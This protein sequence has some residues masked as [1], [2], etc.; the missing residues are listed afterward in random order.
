MTTLWQSERDIPDLT[1]KTYLVT[2]A[3]SGLGLQSTRML[4]A[5]GAHVVMACRSVGRAESA[6]QGVVRD[7]PKASLELLSLDLSDLRHIEAAAETF[8]K[9]HDRLDG[10]LNNAGLMALPLTRTIDGFEMQMGTNHLGHFALTSLLF[11]L[12]I[13]SQGRVVSVSSIMHRFA[14][15]VVEDLSYEKRK[16]DKWE[17]Y[18]NS[19]LAN[20]LFTFELAQRAANLPVK[21]VA[22]HPGYSATDLQGKGPDAEGA[23]LM[24]QLMALSNAFFAQSAELGALPQLRALT[25]PEVENHDYFG[26]KGLFELGGAA[27]RVGYSAAAAN[28]KV[29]AELWQQSVALTGQSFQ[30]LS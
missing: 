20:L 12:L 25:D 22:A 9:K 3:N 17:A 19:K 16:Y 29:A 30:A 23:W 6:K 4:A 5:R 15:S 24:G 18:A 26:P 28:K 10:L 1:G 2:G 27:G 14:R 21:V 11:P 13:K 8:S 7:N